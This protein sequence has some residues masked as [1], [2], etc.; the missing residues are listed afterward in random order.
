MKDL[1]YVVTAASLL[2]CFCS[3]I[4]GGTAAEAY[5][6]KVRKV[7]LTWDAVPNAVMY[8]LVITKGVSARAEDAVRE[9]NEIYTLGYEL[10]TR[11][12]NVRTDNLYWSVRP[13][14]IHR[15]PMGDFSAAK[16]LV[17]GEINPVKPLITG[18]YDKMPYPKAYP[19]YSW[20]PVDKASEYEIQVFKNYDDKSGRTD[21][22][23]QTYHVPEQRSSNYYDDDAY[24]AEGTYW[25]RL[26]AKDRFGMPL[27][28]WSDRQYFK[29]RQQGVKIAALGDS[30]THGGGAVTVP[31]SYM[32]YDWES[33]TGLKILNLGYS[34]DTV[35]KMVKRFNRDVVNFAPDILIIMGGINNIREDDKADFVIGKL[36]QLKYKCLFN[37]IVPVF[38]TVTPVNPKI[39]REVSHI[40]VS[41]GWM[42]EQEK[43]NEWIRKQ[44]LHVD[45]TEELTAPN[46]YLKDSLSTDGLHPDMEAKKMIG[47][48]IGDYIRKEFS[49]AA[50]KPCA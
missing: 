37:G 16:P 13:M 50:D 30:I 40:Y 18:E 24:V 36:N 49:F 22:L 8:Q 44:R 38:V 31:P 3:S 6:G 28:Q 32:M 47:E 33:Y 27:G 46:G 41:E 10:D 39:M 45:V 1:K 2:L 5:G 7:R 12:I 29:V 35:E 42:P 43:V 20:I 23:L 17:D 9:I 15:K 19:V 4:F 48:K 26:R 14:N 25:W 11:L 34:G 21:I